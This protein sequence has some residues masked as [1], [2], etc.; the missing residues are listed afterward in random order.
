[1]LH[2]M[3]YIGVMFCLYL[4]SFQLN[5]SFGWE[6]PSILYSLLWSVPGLTHSS[7]DNS[8]TFFS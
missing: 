7:K 1:M 5:G 3:M 4:C 6:V 2:M 8:K